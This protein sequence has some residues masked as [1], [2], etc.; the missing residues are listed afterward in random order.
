MLT[1]DRTIE[2]TEEMLTKTGHHLVFL[3]V[4]VEILQGLQVRVVF[5]VV[6]IR[7]KLDLAVFTCLPLIQNG[8]NL[9]VT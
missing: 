9:N 8:L 5:R 6:G 4:L 3:C 7:G 2:L 1:K